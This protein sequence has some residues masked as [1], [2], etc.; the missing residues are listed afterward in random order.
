MGEKGAL[1]MNLSGWVVMILSVSGVTA[2]FGISLF[3]VV[4]FE[5]NKKKLHSTLDTT[6]DI[7]KENI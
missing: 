5:K 2:F 3:A 4:R 1:F 7:D 6:P